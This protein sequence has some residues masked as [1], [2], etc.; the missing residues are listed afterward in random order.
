MG[1][2]MCL[3]LPA[4]HDVGVQKNYWQPPKTK[5]PVSNKSTQVFMLADEMN[6]ARVAAINMEWKERRMWAPDFVGV[7]QQTDKSCM[8]KACQTDDKQTEPAGGQTYDFWDWKAEADCLSEGRHCIQLVII[9]TVFV[10]MQY[11]HM[12]SCFWWYV[13]GLDW[14]YTRCNADRVRIHG[15]VNGCCFCCLAQEASRTAAARFTVT[16]TC[17][18]IAS[19]YQKDVKVTSYHAYNALVNS[20]NGR[21]NENHQLQQQSTLSRSSFEWFV[22]SGMGNLQTG[23][24]PLHDRLY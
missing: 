12:L 14:A 21:Q 6:A 23:W 8:S 24:N 18:I 4:R 20:S 15:V 9:L 10:Y 7:A 11:Y 17:F 3:P 13:L 22:H 1:L 5:V 2:S 19:S 16:S